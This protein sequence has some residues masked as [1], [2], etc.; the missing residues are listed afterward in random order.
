MSDFNDIE[1]EHSSGNVFADLGLKNAEEL[2]IRSNLMMKIMDVIIAKGLSQT[3]AAKIM[4]I[5]QP[6]V[7]DLMRG[8]FPRISEHKLMQCLTRLGYD[9]QISVKPKP[10]KNY[11]GQMLFVAA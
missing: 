3:E 8:G 2:K 6:K 10:V 5:S 9:V 4:G 7:S 1:V 11:A